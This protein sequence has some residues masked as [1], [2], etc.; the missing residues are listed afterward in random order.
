MRNPTTADFGTVP[1]KFLFRLNWPLFRPAA[2]LISDVLRFYVKKNL[3]KI[4][5]KTNNKWF[6]KL[7]TLSEFEEQITMTNPPPADQTIGV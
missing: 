2:A 7:T 3:N 6:D 5:Q 4:A 1:Q